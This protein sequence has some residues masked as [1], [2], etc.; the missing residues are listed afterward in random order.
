MADR[1]KRNDEPELEPEQELLVREINQELKQDK[2]KKVWAKYGNIAIAFAVLVVLGVGGYKFWQ[3]EQEKA[4]LAA[5]ERYA[6]AVGLI[7]DGKT[8]EATDALATLVRDAPSGY[9]ALARLQEAAAFAKQGD[10]ANSMRVYDALTKDDR[11][12]RNVRELALVLYG[13]HALDSADPVA[14]VERMKP[15]TEGKNAWRYTA[16]EI[17][18]LALDKAGKRAEAREIFGRLA[19]DA[20]A[21]ESLRARARAMQTILGSS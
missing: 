1:K 21:P 13:W 5:S 10:V 12:D 3:G 19:S 2:Y 6:V 17:T 7:K 11:V 4:K 20:E 8:K 16:T 18:G 15:L 9:A 14:L